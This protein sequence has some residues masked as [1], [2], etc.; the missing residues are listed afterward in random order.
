MFGYSDIEFI[1][2]SASGFQK[3]IAGLRAAFPPKLLTEFLWVWTSIRTEAVGNPFSILQSHRA[4]SELENQI[5]FFIRKIILQRAIF[6]ANATFILELDIR[7]DFL[8]CI[9]HS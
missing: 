2:E 9:F 8:L 7:F 1:N 3:K 5:L 6:F 4:P